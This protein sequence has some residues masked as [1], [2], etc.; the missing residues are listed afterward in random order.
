[1]DN[2]I[3]FSPLLVWLVLMII[4]LVVEIITVGLVCIWF[5][6]GALLALLSGLFGMPVV[7]QIILFFA[8]S[9]AM[10]F[11]TRPFVQRFVKPHNV[12]TNYE[13]LIGREVLVTDRIDNRAG[14]G[15]AVFN[16]QEWTARSIQDEVTI[17]SGEAAVVVEIKGVKLYVR[18]K[19]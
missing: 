1:M 18:R 10:V 16:G 3:E 13:E 7:G 15:T 2:F 5:A 19:V 6:G 14:T 11:G 12:R 4:F 9:F 17:E 8:A